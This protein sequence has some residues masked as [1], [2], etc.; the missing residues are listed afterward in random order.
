LGFVQGKELEICAFIVFQL[1]LKL[2]QTGL[3]GAVAKWLE[4][5]VILPDESLE[6]G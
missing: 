5:S 3:S 2:N 6:F 1:H 4:A